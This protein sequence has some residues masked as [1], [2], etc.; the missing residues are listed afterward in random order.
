M[1]QSNEVSTLGQVVGLS[2]RMLRAERGITQEQA[3]ALLRGVGLEW[4]RANVASL[5]SGRRQDLTVTELVRLS[6]AF[7]VPLRRWLEASGLT[8][9]VSLG[10]GALALNH[11]LAGL[12]D[13]A[14]PHEPA[15][16]PLSVDPEPI[17]LE[18]ELHAAERLGIP[19]ERLQQ[20]AAQLWGRRLVEEREHRL[21]A[22]VSSP[23]PASKRGHV[24]RA[25]LRE[26]E[27]AQ[28]EG[29]R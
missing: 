17:Y 24:T 18:A 29:T 14:S 15:R 2:L 11:G 3:V 27:A 5:E 25:L 23:I 4:T 1:A 10:G 12:L 6:M 13:G 20:L 8:Y 26:L 19:P 21:E 22:G 28:R 9:M 7:G 16:V